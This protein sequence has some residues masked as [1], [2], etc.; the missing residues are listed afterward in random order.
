MK[1]TI[2]G[3]G[4][5]CVDLVFRVDNAFLQKLD[6]NKGDE[7]T[8]TWEKFSRILEACATQ[9]YSPLIAVGGS[10]ANTI[11]G[12]A[13]L[14]HQ[15]S[16]LGK[17]GQDTLGEL[18]LEKHK[19]LN[20]HSLIVQD[21]TP[22][23]QIAVFVTEDFQRSFLAFLGAGTQL[24]AGDL[25]LNLFQGVRHVHIEGYMLDNGTLVEQATRLAKQAQATVSLDLGC[26]RIVEKYRN[27]IVKLLQSSVDIVFANENETRSLVQSSDESGAKALGQYCPIAVVLGGEKGCWVA[28]KGNIIHSPALKVKVVD[29]TG[30][31]DL[32]AAGFLHGFLKGYTLE[33][34]AVFGNVLGGT[35][36]SVVGAEIQQHQWPDIIKQL[37]S[38]LA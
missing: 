38:P 13:H 34:C 14:K 23:T 37:S 8:A 30:A 31:G 2:L 35:V 20:I 5:P 18:Y 27:T 6:V 7:K 32:F 19:A 24:N 12:L 16:F 21:K 28:A 33:A 17:I 11:R 3:I 36:V 29:T 4:S 10:A 15:A 25:N 26:L 9:G 22:T 1:N